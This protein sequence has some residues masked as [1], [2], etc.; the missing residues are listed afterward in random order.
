MASSH[1]RKD[2][3]IADDEKQRATLQAT[4]AALRE[5]EQSAVAERAQLLRKIDVLQNKLAGAERRLTEAKAHRLS[6][7][8][9]IGL[10][11]DSLQVSEATVAAALEKHH[12][13]VADLYT[14]MLKLEALCEK[15]QQE[16]EEMEL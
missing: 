13:G 5:K 8:E 15:S 10:S 3:Q 9:E 1:R 2:E 16:K 12:V 7:R 6:L 4:L 14:R 11:L